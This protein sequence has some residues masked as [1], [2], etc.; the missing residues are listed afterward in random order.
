MK[1]YFCW[2]QKS[3]FR[4]DHDWEN[5][6]RVAVYSARMNTDLTPI[7]VIDGVPSTLTCELERV[8]VKV[9]FHQ[10]KFYDEIARNF[11]GHGQMAHVAAGAFLRF[12]IPILENEDEFVLYTDC[13]VMFLRNPDLSIKAET[14]LFAAASQAAKNNPEDMNSGVLLMN[15]KNMKA[16]YDNLVNF[17]VANF[18]LGLDQEILR[19]YF[20]LDYTRLPPSLNWKPYWG[21]RKDMEIIHWHG[22]KPAAVKELLKNNEAPAPKIWAGMFRQAAADYAKF[23]P[24]YSDFLHGARDML[25]R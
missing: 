17:A 22:P 21:L 3:N 8:G 9:V 5:L 13:D 15:I 24:M 4:A 11:G 16:C 23:Y 18:S 10:L 1:W 19:A 7:A 14:N 6:I 2:S 25:C 20:R 12:D